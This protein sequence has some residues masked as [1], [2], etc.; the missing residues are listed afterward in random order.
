MK[1]L[2]HSFTGRLL[3]GIALIHFLLL[4]LLIGSIFFIVQQG[5]RTQF[6][7]HVRF[8]SAMF[9]GLVAE[10]RSR[11]HTQTLLS[12][13]VYSGFF[14]FAQVVDTKARELV[15]VADKPGR[16]HFKED[17]FFGRHGDHVYY[18]SLPLVSH[19]GQRR[20]ELRL[21]YDETETEEQVGQIYQRGL[22]A[23]LGY[24]LLGMLLVLFWGRRMTR[25]LQELRNASRAIA[26]GYR[27]RRLNVDTNI[28]EVE[29]LAEDLD[30]MRAELAKQ[31]TALEH[32]ASHDVLTGLPNRSLLM[33]RLEHTIKVCNRASEPL[34]LLLMD[35]DGFKEVNDTLGH[36]TGDH[37]LQQVAMRISHVVRD[38]DTVARLGGDEFSFILPE[39]GPARART[40]VD[41][42]LLVLEQPF[43]L[44]DHPIQ[45]GASIGIAVFPDHGSGPD[46]LGCAD[47]AMYE[48]KRKGS[49]CEIYHGGLERDTLD[50]MTLASELRQGI[51]K[52][53]LV[54][55]YQPKIDLRTD[56]LCGA[57]C[58]IR[59]NH[60]QR[61]LIPPNDFISIAERTG[62]IGAL[63][64][65]MADESL[66]QLKVWR[67]SGILDELSINFSARNLHEERMPER[68]VD[69]MESL[70][71]DTT[72]LQIELTESAIMEDPVRAEIVFNQ[73][74]A[75]GILLS[76]DDFGTGYS[77]LVH[78]KRLPV[79]EIKIDRSF[80]R[81]MVHNKNDA[82]IVH[83]T[84]N[85]GHSLGLTVVAEGVE[86]EEVFEKLR[87]QGCDII[88]GYYISP[89][90]PAEKFEQWY[91]AS[92]WYRPKS[93]NG[94]K[95]V[96]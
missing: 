52:D 11:E 64:Y 10:K 23:G 73:L 89:P 59:W 35:L 69:L 36:L 75:Q 58:L 43:I 21:G 72:C 62:L 76:I 4:P 41:K 31:A 49:G 78:L 45:I 50:Q 19:N 1:G 94:F 65:W 77:S 79:S 57:E 54:V 14:V 29:T 63:T 17:F 42:I 66:H 5:Y 92:R 46:L 74:H 12:D 3:I 80:V 86:D 48:A 7:T 34:A 70:Q 71:L 24:L 37:L 16:R 38:S 95:S 93:A 47:V 15:L 67:Q 32:Q 40:V 82:A 83:A 28:T 60:P 22:L 90:L 2:W 53:Q 13:A 68:L 20:G 8:N 33:S 85:L 18:V 87:Q 30:Y 84:I 56:R 91:R 51:E 6:I 88:Q 96:N 39:V 25:P 26:A 44:D 61:G 55:Y 27:D 9:A 81:D